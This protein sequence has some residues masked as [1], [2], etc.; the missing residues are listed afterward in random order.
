M[1]Y[2]DIMINDYGIYYKEAMDLHGKMVF[3]NKKRDK[4]IRMREKLLGQ[5]FR[6]IRSLIH[7]DRIYR[8]NEKLAVNE[9]QATLNISRVM[10][11]TEKAFEIKKDLLKYNTKQIEEKI[12]E[13]GIDPSGGLA[14]VL[15]LQGKFDN[16]DD[17]DEQSE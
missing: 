2:E 9:V 8:Y 14:A 11:L 10:E 7:A 17:S 4:L 3:L 1:K 12:R 15:A 5:K 16:Y 13:C 6:F